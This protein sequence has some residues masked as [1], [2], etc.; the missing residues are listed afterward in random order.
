MKLNAPS[1]KMENAFKCCI[2]QQ[3][4]LPHEMGE[5][6]FEEEDDIQPNDPGA[7]GGR[8]HGGEEDEL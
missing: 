7:R 2:Y 1:T 5:Q 6:P 4:F 8:R 3:G